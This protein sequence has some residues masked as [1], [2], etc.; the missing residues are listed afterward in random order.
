MARS[1]PQYGG[2]CGD[3][4]S[5]CHDISLSHSLAHALSHVKGRLIICFFLYLFNSSIFV[6]FVSFV[7]PIATKPDWEGKEKD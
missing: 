6:C 2:V 3:P 7:H 1:M 4:V 5:I